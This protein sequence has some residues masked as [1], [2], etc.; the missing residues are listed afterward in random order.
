MPWLLA[1]KETGSRYYRRLITGNEYTVESCGEVMRKLTVLQSRGLYTVSEYTAHMQSR[2]GGET[3]EIGTGVIGL[4]ILGWNQEG[5]MKAQISKKKEK[6]K[7]R[8]IQRRNSGNSL[9]WIIQ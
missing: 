2:G 1:S 6:E 5:K 8:W 9:I 7:E 3:N 4:A